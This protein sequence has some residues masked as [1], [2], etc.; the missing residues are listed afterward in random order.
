LFA[1]RSGERPSETSVA[2]TLEAEAALGIR[3]PA[4]Y[5]QFARRALDLRE[6]LRE[7]LGRL[8]ADGRRIAAY[9]ASA[10][11][12]TLLNFIGLAPGTLEFVVDRSPHKQGR[13]TPGTHLPI[14]PPEFLIARQP[15]YTLLLTWNFADEILHQQQ[16]YRDRGGRFI[17]PLPELRI[18]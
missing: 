15:D 5:D 12:S 17:I 18:V 10:K 16:A 8:H 4:V 2:P 1:A 3:G 11:G 6:R 7:L 14:H 13:H 9:G